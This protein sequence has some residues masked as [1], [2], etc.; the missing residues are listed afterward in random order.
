MKKYFDEQTTIKDLCLDEDVGKYMLYLYYPQRYLDS[1]YNQTVTE[2]AK[3]GL[4]AF[5]F[6]KKAVLER[7]VKQYFVN[8]KKPDVSFIHISHNNHS[9]VIF[10]LSGGGLYSVCHGIE[11]LP[12]ASKLFEKGFDIL[13]LTY[14]I[15]DGAYK[16]GPVDDLASSIKY[17]FEHE[18]ELN[19]DMKDYSVLGCSAAGFVAAH[20]GTSLN[21]YKKYGL[22]KPYMLMLIYP[23]INLRTCLNDQTAIYCLRREYSEENLHNW[24]VDEIVDKDY[25]RTFILH[26]KDDSIV[27]FNNAEWMVNS[28]KKYQISYFYKAYEK[29]GHG[30]SI[31]S[32]ESARG[33]V[34]LLI[35]YYEQKEK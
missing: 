21:G 15:D 9:R 7:K 18:N 12:I 25:P 33:W 10:I 35:D 13:L 31:A 3:Y 34:D 16:N 23:V 8:A 5:N 26:C 11:G 24:S 1:V 27:S 20:Y 17:A 2:T 29:G 6:F 28:L 30:W 19:I 22:P 14:S 4:E 32:E